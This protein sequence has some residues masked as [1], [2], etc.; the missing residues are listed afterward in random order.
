MSVQSELASLNSVGNGQLGNLSDAGQKT[1][2]LANPGGDISMD[3]TNSMGAFKDEET[4]STER[5]EVREESYDFTATSSKSGS[6]GVMGSFA[7]D[8]ASG[9]LASI[10]ANNFSY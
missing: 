7:A 4:G 9:S 8:S 3:A 6:A 1:G 5:F 10:N 2:L